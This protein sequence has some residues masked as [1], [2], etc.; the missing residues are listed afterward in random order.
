M[1]LRRL[2]AE[3]GRNDSEQGGLTCEFRRLT[4]NSC[5]VLTWFPFSCTEGIQ[6]GW[7]VSYMIPY[8]TN[9]HLWTN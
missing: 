5:N 1:T 3:G 2:A 7:F 6:S 4:N 8:P 9:K